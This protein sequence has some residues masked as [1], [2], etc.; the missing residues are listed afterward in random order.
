MRNHTLPPVRYA[1]ACWTSLKAARQVSMTMFFPCN[2]AVYDQEMP[3]GPMST[4]DSAFTGGAFAT[5]RI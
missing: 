3:L 1:D 4:V 5:R 2:G